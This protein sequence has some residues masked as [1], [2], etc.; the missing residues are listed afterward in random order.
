MHRG[1][2]W[3]EGVGGGG[4][5]SFMKVLLFVSVYRTVLWLSFPPPFHPS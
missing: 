1:I 2:A 3:T 4:G 5:G